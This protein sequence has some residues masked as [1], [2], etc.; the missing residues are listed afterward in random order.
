MPD[1][2]A[3]IA[4]AAATGTTINTGIPVP[5]RTSSWTPNT[6]LAFDYPPGPQP[7]EFGGLPK[8]YAQFYD[9]MMDS[10]PQSAHS[11]RMSIQLQDLPYPPN[12]S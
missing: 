5:S 1:N 9:D 4:V 3:C 8:D 10:I 6:M 12:S 11:L 7:L 2:N